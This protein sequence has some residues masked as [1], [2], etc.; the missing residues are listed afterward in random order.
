MRSQYRR[1][2]ENRVT[3]HL[4][5]ANLC[6]RALHPKKEA[7]YSEDLTDDDVEAVDDAALNTIA[8]LRHLIHILL[9]DSLLA[10]N[11]VQG[12]CGVYAER[13]LESHLRRY[14]QVRCRSIAGE[15]PRLFLKMTSQLNSSFGLVALGSDRRYTY[16]LHHW[17]SILLSFASQFEM[18]LGNFASTLSR[19]FGVHSRLT[20][21][22]YG[23]S[24]N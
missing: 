1:L 23:L 7:I 8:F 15:V 22:F 4:N 24:I 19:D 12:A 6:I 11:N 16:H 18:L 21:D 3:E 10:Q 17:S 5:D 20:E 14:S 2:I 9:L 13:V